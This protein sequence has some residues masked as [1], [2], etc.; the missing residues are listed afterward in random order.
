MAISGWF[1]AAYPSEAY[2]QAGPAST[3]PEADIV[4]R[5]ILMAGAVPAA[6]T[7]YLRTKM[8]ET[9]R[10]TAL[11]ANDA[12]RAASDMSTVLD[13]VMTGKNRHVN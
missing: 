7:Y 1:G 9:A 10:Y 12:A 5:A 3:V 2:E 13:V 8:P 4:W 11:V 6:L